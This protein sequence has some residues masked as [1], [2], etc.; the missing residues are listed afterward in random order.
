MT[1][2]QFLWR[3]IMYRPI[4]YWINALVWTVIYLAPIAPGSN[5]EAIL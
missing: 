3:L 2:F 5:Y 4:R 1:T